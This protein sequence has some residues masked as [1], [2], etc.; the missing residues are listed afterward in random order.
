MEVTEVLLQLEDLDEPEFLGAAVGAG[1][2]A[3]M[4]LFVNH[5]ASINNVVGR[6]LFDEG[7]K[8]QTSQHGARESMLPVDLLGAV[9]VGVSAPA[10]CIAT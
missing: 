8:R 7:G 9:G 10:P 2:V 5:G 1:Q 4:E 6:F 3:V